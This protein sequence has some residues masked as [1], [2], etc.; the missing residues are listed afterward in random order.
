[1]KYA[2]V[3]KDKTGYWAAIDDKGNQIGRLQDTEL[4]AMREANN[5][6]YLVWS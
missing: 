4:D 1:M 3:I 2:R 6:K 5:N